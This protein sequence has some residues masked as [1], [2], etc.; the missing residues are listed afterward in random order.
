MCIISEIEHIA[1]SGEGNVLAP[2]CSTVYL[3]TYSA[4]EEKCE[5]PW[6]KLQTKCYLLVDD[7]DDQN[8]AKSLKICEDKDAK[9]ISIGSQDDFDLITKSFPSS[10]FWLG[11]KK[12]KVM[13]LQVVIL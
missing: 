1:G 2:F 5:A 3:K 9:L 13:S 6:K 12:V 7:G 10:E 4:V 8:Y 11:A